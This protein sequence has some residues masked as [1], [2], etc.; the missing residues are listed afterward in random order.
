MRVVFL[1]LN[2][3]TG[4][5]ALPEDF[6]ITSGILNLNGCTAL[7]LLPD[8]MGDVAGLNLN[9]CSHITALPNGLKVS[10]WIDI[11]GTAITEI[12]E[13]YAHVGF[14]RG[15]DVISAEDALAS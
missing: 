8:D 1:K 3:C 11:T 12:P 7:K 4:I 5:A 10:S 13:A 6:R 14:R 9:G 15:N 2:G